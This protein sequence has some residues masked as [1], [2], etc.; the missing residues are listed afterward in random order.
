VAGHPSGHTGVL[1]GN[2]RTGWHYFSFSSGK[3]HFNPFGGNKADNMDYRGYRT[4]AAARRDPAMARYLKY[5]RWTTS[6]AADRKAIDAVRPYFHRAYIICGQTCDDV[7]VEALWAAGVSCQDRWRPVDTFNSN[8][9]NADE[10]G[11]FYQ[12]PP[13]PPR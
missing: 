6:P 8:K 4:L 5:A 11:T 7:A 3:C 9:D 10:S 12:P 13:P 1:I 2:D